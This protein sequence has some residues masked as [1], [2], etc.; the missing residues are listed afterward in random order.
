MISP[1]EFLGSVPEAPSLGSTD[2]SKAA[3]GIT[4]KGA[5]SLTLIEEARNYLKSDDK[6]ISVRDFEPP[7]C[8]QNVFEM[9]LEGNDVHRSWAVKEIQYFIS[10][11]NKYKDGNVDLHT[12]ESD[13]ISLSSNLVFFSAWVNYLDSIGA[14]SERKRKDAETRA[15][16]ELR[17]WC[18][19]EELG[20]RHF[21]VETMRAVAV[22]STKD[23]ADFQTKAMVI[24]ST[25]KGFY[26][27]LKDF[28]SYLDR[29]SQR[30]QAERLGGRK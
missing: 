30:M 17:N 23:M 3:S 11:V 2:L 4:V 19:N 28:I 26:Y 1:G 22:E 5:T 12:V 24:A 15:F 6:K 18:E 25:I 27:A 8:Y 21:G 16:L 9:P 13:I 7:P 10:V 29:V 14:D 20:P